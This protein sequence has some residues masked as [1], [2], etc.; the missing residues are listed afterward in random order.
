MPQ[1]MM[2][3][4]PMGPTPQGIPQDT[5]P[6]GAGQ[7]NPVIEALQTVA[8][9][10]AGLEEKGLNVEKIKSTLQ[11][12][13]QSFMELGQGKQEPGQEV[14]GPVAPKEKTFSRDMP[15]NARAGSVPIM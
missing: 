13:I 6:E 12:L 4:K 9:A 3:Q 10:V 11:I 1:E 5:P 2:N 7:S 14:P 15:A 8:M